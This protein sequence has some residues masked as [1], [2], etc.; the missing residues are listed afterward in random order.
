MPKLPTWLIKRAPKSQNIK[1]LRSLINDPKIHTVCESAK[2][3]NI[4]E[5]YSRKTMTFMILGNI[6][7]RNCRFCAVEHGTPLPV[8]ESEP[9]RVA[10]AAKKLGLKYV[11][12][13]SVTRDDLPDG[14]ANQFAKTINDLRLVLRSESEGGLTINEIRVEVLIPDF[15]DNTKALK[16]VIEASPDVINHN[17][18]TVPRLYPE[19][20]PQANY[21]WSLNL[22]QNVKK[23]DKNICTKS[24]LMVGLGERFDEVVEVLS[25]LRRVDCAIVTLGQY[26]SPSKAHA[27]VVEYVKPE[28]FEKY[29]TIGLEM[30]FKHLFSGPFVRSSY[31]AHKIFRKS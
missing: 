23:I 29:K 6:C 19:I 30:G 25:D 20:R 3:P 13:T 9:K 21:Q 22:L 4:G 7:T 11:V 15:K 1:K 2:C 14:G 10:K 26:I 8:D 24:G 5:C 28:V 16:K 31:Q 12:V 27:A 17:V 18:E